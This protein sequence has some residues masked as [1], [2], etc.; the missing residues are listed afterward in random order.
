MNYPVDKEFR[1]LY[2]KSATY[3]WRQLCKSVAALRNALTN[4]LEPKLRK[5]IEY[6]DN[7]FGHSKKSQ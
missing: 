2:K 6:V 5:V 3:Q 1:E 7:H 4:E